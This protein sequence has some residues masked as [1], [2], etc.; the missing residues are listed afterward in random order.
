MNGLW[1]VAEFPPDVGQLN[2]LERDFM[3]DGVNEVLTL[4]HD[5]MNSYAALGFNEVD[6]PAPAVGSGVLVS[7]TTRQLSM[8]APDNH[9]APQHGDAVRDVP[10]TAGEVEEAAENRPE[11]GDAFSVVVDQAFLLQQSGKPVQDLGLGQGSGKLIIVHLKLVEVLPL[12]L[13][14]SYAAI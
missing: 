6:D 9:A 5:E 10:A 7:S 12:Q 13:R 8:A 3:L 1:R 14:D 11:A 4:A 2:D